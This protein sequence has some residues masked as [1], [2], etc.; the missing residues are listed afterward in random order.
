MQV[1][2]IMDKLWDEIN[3]DTK[4]QIQKEVSVNIDIDIESKHLS[5]ALWE[6]EELH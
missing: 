2:D 1:F 6:M 4:D 5:K 3:T